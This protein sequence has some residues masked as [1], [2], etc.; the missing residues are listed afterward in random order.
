MRLL[1]PNRAEFCEHRDE[2]WSP[3]LEVAQQDLN[4]Y[5]GLSVIRSSIASIRTAPNTECSCCYQGK[6]TPPQIII[7]ECLPWSIAHRRM[8]PN[9]TGQSE[10]RLPGS[11]ILLTPVQSRLQASP[12]STGTTFNCRSLHLTSPRIPQTCLVH[13]FPVSQVRIFLPVRISSVRHWCF[14]R[15]HRCSYISLK[16]EEFAQRREL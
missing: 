8:G 5:T 15:L 1:F 10:F 6:Q 13:E 12:Q 11:A 16:S 7:N 4:G 2:P 14:C 9:D 3:V